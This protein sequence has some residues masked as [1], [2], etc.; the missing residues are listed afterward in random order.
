MAQ[1]G[2]TG[3][4]D[5]NQFVPSRFKRRIGIDVQDAHRP[6]KLGRK[7]QQAIDEIVTQVTPFATHHGEFAY[8]AQSPARRVT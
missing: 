4:D 3:E 7:G 5:G 2:V 1:L 6:P 8:H